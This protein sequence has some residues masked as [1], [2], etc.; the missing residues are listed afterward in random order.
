MNETILRVEKLS[1]KYLLSEH[2]GQEE[3][4]ALKDVSFTVNKKEVV[5][6]IG[7]NGSGK[8]TLLKILSSVTFPTS[9][10]VWKKAW[11]S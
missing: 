10:K 11:F 3:F 8:S 9:G 4:W 7:E 5:G 6:I 2:K 1:K